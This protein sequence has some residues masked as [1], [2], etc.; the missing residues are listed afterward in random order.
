MPVRPLARLVARLADPDLLVAV[1]RV[2]VVRERLPAHHP[3]GL[4]LG[5]LVVTDNG[6]LFASF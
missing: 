4:R 6:R 3:R 1:V 5:H 2:M